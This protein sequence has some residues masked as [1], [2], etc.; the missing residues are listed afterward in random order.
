ME[1]SNHQHGHIIEI[2]E[3]YPVEEP[4]EG[5]PK[6]CAGAACGFSDSGTSSK[7]AKEWSASIRKLLIDIVL[8]VII[9]SVEV[10]GGIKANR[11]AILIDS[12]HLYLCSLCGQQ[13]GKRLHVNHMSSSG[14]R[15]SGLL[16]PYR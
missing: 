11:L 16:F 10:V 13:G 9:M 5:G 8:R 6:V 7:D 15:S 14:L 4:S 3:P 12:S 2:S 1:E